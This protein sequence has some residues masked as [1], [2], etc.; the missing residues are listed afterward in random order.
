MINFVLNYINP[1][2]YKI[3]YISIIGIFVGA[4][5]LLVRKILDKKISPKWK[6]II[7]ILL[8]VELVVPIK[9]TI[10]YKY[11]NTEIISI[12]GLAEPI[13]NISSYNQTTNDEEITVKKA[14]NNTDSIIQNNT[15]D[16][17]Q[18]E[19]KNICVNLI[20]PL[21]WIAGILINLVFIIFGE[22]N[23]KKNIKGK[24]Y[25]DKNLK[26]LLE[27]CKAKL[28]IKNNVEIMLQE[29]KKTPSIIGVFKPKILI[30]QEFLGQ[31]EKTKKYIIMH[32][33][34]HYKRKDSLFNYV[35]LIITVIHWFNP[36]VWI[37]FKK[38]RQDIE[39]ATDE[40]V[41]EKLQKNEKKEYGMTL[42]NSLQIFQEEPYTAKLLCVTDDNKNMERRIKMVKLSDKF[43]KNKILIC[44]ISLIVIVLGILLFFTQSNQYNSTK[45]NDETIQKD[46]TPKYEFRTF[47]PS[48]KSTS[49]SDYDDYDFTQDMTY[50]DKIYYK[51]INTYNEYE[52]EITISIWNKL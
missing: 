52:K 32:E 2:F 51:K 48:F 23:I 47:K 12:S 31:D 30:T 19:N 27:E 16:K 13:Q 7:W 50:M 28:H 18:E 4:F 39:L 20:L 15:E 8:M 41:L 36:F 22:R 5:I 34:S 46:E 43:S 45:T 40:M 9:F 26:N 33:L 14:E 17:K 10:P 42:I 3:L 44:V 49:D 6:C 24:K 11:K 1:I 37:F 21:L 25:I 38:I 29:F 35:L